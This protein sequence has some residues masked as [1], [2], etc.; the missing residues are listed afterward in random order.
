MVCYH[1]HNVVFLRVSLIFR[2]AEGGAPPGRAGKS[3]IQRHIK[4]SGTVRKGED[5]M[6]ISKSARRV[7]A[8]TLASLL[9]S[10]VLP[11]SGIFA[12]NAGSAQD[13][14]TNPVQTGNADPFVFQY[15]GTYY[16]YGTNVNASAYGFKVYTS[17]DLV[18]WKGNDQ[19][20]LTPGSGNWGDKNFWAPEVFTENGKFY[21]LYAAEVSGHS[22]I[23]IAQSDSPLGPFTK[24]G[25]QALETDSID[26]DY[27]RDSDGNRYLYY[28]HA[29]MVYGTTLGADLTTVGSKKL[30][31][32]RYSQPESWVHD[33]VVEAPEMF[34]HNGTYYLFYSAN[35]VGVDYGVGYATA[36]G[37]LGPFTKSASNPILKKS[38]TAFGPGHNSFAASPDGTELFMVY[39]TLYSSS[40]GDPRKTCIDRMH[41]VPQANGPDLVTVDGPTDTPQPMPGTSGVASSGSSAA[42][43]SSSPS[44]VSSSPSS[45][46]ASGFY[47]MEDGDITGDAEPEAN[48]PGFTGAGF[49][50][51]WTAGSTDS[52][53]VRADKAGTYP[54][55]IRYANGQASKRSIT[56]SVNGNKTDLVF[57]VVKSG[58]WESWGSLKA[59]IT[60]NAG[61]NAVVFI[62]DSADKSAF[63]LDNFAIDFTTSIDTSSAVSSAPVSSAV[64]SGPVSSAVSSTPVSSAVSSGPVPSA[65]V[66]SLVSSAPVSSVSSAE[67][68]GG[69]SDQGSLS[70]ESG[71]AAESGGVS[72][73]G[74]TDASPNTGTT[75]TASL[76]AAILALSSLSVA[77][78]K[79]KMK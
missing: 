52:F 17:K 69:D 45:A 53:T 32:S 36:S 16:L 62:A 26:A 29:G 76:F 54:L 34:K 12:E 72:S 74:S 58:D 1:C 57:P 14:Y 64:S 27:F 75:A 13:T 55:T 50:A 51:A 18:N 9:A 33:D 49:V 71:S 2:R 78:L 70:T 79:K 40:Q 43:S 48:H 67:S 22:N 73:A 56:L 21:M 42:S 10:T 68:S 77:A 6:K 41:F 15:N 5:S 23:Y 30:L 66:S 20:A 46:S 24:Y 4:I 47:E 31:L 38:A 65:P 39:A 19:L 25:T 37:P 8:V 7:L 60:L 28:N 59:T 3:V 11:M 63:N 61:D 35:G 44:S